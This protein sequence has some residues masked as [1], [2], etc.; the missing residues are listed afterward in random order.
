MS[1]P[2]SSHIIQCSRAYNS[3]FHEPKATP[4][5]PRSTKLSALYQGFNYVSLR[6]DA[7]NSVLERNDNEV[8]TSPNGTLKWPK[9]RSDPSFD[10]FDQQFFLLSSY[11]YDPRNE[12]RRDAFINCT[13]DEILARLSFE[14]ISSGNPPGERLLGELDVVVVGHGDFGRGGHQSVEFDFLL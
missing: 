2:K 3:K 7:S 11:R 14:M 9:A 1:S 6:L 4:P 10:D 5:K 8:I 13:M 12:H